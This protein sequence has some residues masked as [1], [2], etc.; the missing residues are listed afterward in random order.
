MLGG[1]ALQSTS[2][3]KCGTL[4]LSLKYINNSISSNYKCPYIENLLQMGDRFFAPPPDD[5]LQC[6]QNIKQAANKNWRR[7]KIEENCCGFQIQAGTKWREG[8]TQTALAEFEA[9]MGYEFPVS[10]KNYY[11]TMNGPDTPGIDVQGS[12]GTPIMFIS[13]SHSGNLGLFL[14]AS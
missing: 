12:G 7:A 9:A 11:L 10:L 4:C 2:V 14:F 3:P 8:L 6:F 1:R 5:S 13:K